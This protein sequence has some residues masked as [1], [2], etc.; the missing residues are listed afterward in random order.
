MYLC[1]FLRPPHPVSRILV[2][3]WDVEIPLVDSLVPVT[4]SIEE[5]LEA[6]ISS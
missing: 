6:W 2:E 5:W 4:A 1:D 3:V